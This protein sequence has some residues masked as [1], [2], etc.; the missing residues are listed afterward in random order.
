M[1]N[2]DRIGFLEDEARFCA[3]TITSDLASLA[4]YVFM[5]T[6]S[7]EKH[8]LDYVLTCLAVIQK[9]AKSAE[10]TITKLQ[11]AQDKANRLRENGID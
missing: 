9:R 3:E 1:D 8:R 11:N 5:A 10:G 2:T 6:R 7:N 4:D